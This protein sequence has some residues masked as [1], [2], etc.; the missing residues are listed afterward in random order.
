[1]KEF[2][3]ENP[4]FLTTMKSVFTELSE[5]GRPTLANQIQKYIDKIK[6]IVDAPAELTDDDKANV[7]LK[8][9][10]TRGRI[11]EQ[12]ADDLNLYVRVSLDCKGNRID[13]CAYTRD[14]LDRLDKSIFS[15]YINGLDTASVDKRLNESFDKLEQV[16]KSYKVDEVEKLKQEEE[17]LKAQLKETKEKLKKAEKA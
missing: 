8:Y 9:V 11:L 3:S 2:I 5:L 4:T 14:H 17:S 1:M 6:E 7:T 10:A 15:S 13:I 16:I 12:M